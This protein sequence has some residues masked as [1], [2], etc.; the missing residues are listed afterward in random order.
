MEGYKLLKY[1]GM[2]I[3]NRKKGEKKGEI[4]KTKPRTNG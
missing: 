3:G 1:P 2:E 4:C